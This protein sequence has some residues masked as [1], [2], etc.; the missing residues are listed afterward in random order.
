MS[1]P[2]LVPKKM[3]S[4]LRPD[5]KY[6][7]HQLEGVRWLNA[8]DSWV[9]A[10]E[11]GLGKTLQALSAAAI[12]WDARGPLRILV[13]CDAKLKYNWAHEIEKL[14]LFSSHILD[15][16]NY[17][18]RKRSFDFY[19]GFDTNI[20]IAHYDQFVSRKVAQPDG[21]VK[22]SKVVE[23]LFDI[24]WDIII[25][26]EAHALK[27][28]KAARTKAMHKLKTRRWFLLTGTPME[29]RPDEL[30]SLLK[31]AIPE[32]QSYWKWV[33]RFCLFG[34]YGGHQVV[35]VKKKDELRA[36]LEEVMLR[37]LKRDCLDLPEKQHIQVLCELSDYQKDLYKEVVQDLRLTLPENPDPMEVETGL[38]RSLR[39]RQICSTPSNL[40]GLDD[41]SGKLDV[42]VEEARNYL[43][44]GHKI[45]VFTEFRGTLAA[46]M[47]RFEKAGIDQYVVHGGIELTDRAFAQDAFTSHPRPCVFLATR[48]SCGIGLTLTAADVLFFVDKP[49]G[50]GKVQQAEDRIHRIGAKDSVTIVDFICAGTYEE[51]IEKST[52]RKGEAIDELIP[53]AGWKKRVYDAIRST[54]TGF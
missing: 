28:W 51:Q 11:P 39:L 16:K 42:V 52:E 1:G 20:L 32:T 5:L 9:L 2:T 23:E 24:D 26:D 35:G 50:P 44:N 49:F 3:P 29:N 53:N 15:G 19:R 43:S 47:N 41:D 48:Q 33:Q 40:E 25:A 30:W 17:D 14:T 12:D 46:L 34:G 21:S 8:R 4:K 38:K 13:V 36:Y 10:D 27:S 37:R 45:V 7:K 31:L 22:N 18:E 6:Y 54:S